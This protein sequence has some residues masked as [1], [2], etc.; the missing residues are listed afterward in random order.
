MKT[1]KGK[2]QLKSNSFKKY[3]TLKADAMKKIKMGDKF[4]NNAQ[5]KN[6]L[7]GMIATR[8]LNAAGISK[9]DDY[10]NYPYNIMNSVS[11]Y[12]KNVLTNSDVI[13]TFGQVKIT[14]GDL[15]DMQQRYVYEN[16]LYF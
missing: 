12:N 11:I 16:Y 4:K 8:T 7:A 5:L 3:N 15:L 13:F 1:V 2:K 6:Y 14:Y 10:M 9:A